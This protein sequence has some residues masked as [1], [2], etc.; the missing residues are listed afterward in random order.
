MCYEKVLI[1]CKK[2][3]MVKALQ[4]TI[5]FIL[6]MSFS[7]NAQDQSNWGFSNEFV[8]GINKNTNG[9]LIGG[10]MVK[11]AR[12]KNDRWMEFF[13]LELSNVKHPKE[14]R[15]RTF[16]GNAYI[17]GK[18]N[19]LYAVRPNYGR[20]LMLFKKA[21]NQGVQV[22]LL[23]AIGPTLG[24]VAPYYIEL[25]VDA[26]NSVRV[27]FDHTV[28]LNQS[29]LLGSGRVFQGLF[30]SQFEIGAHG[31]VGL[32]F[33]FGAF[34]SNVT[35]LELGLMHEAFRNEIII[36]PT[37]DNRSRFTSAYVTL[38]FGRRN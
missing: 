17:W 16:I 6:A 14:V 1:L 21:P 29:N 34:R 22:S 3:I 24:V 8:W 31:R 23:G 20:E 4:I 30:D 25:A 7:L 18:E 12:P 35:G 2:S 38:Y 15:Y 28:H 13:G 26:L 10:V 9:G 11:Y 5:V 36:I 37:A 33:E 19:Y 32:N 27:P